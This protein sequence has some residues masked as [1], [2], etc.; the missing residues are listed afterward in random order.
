MLSKPADL[1]LMNEAILD[2]DL[3]RNTFLVFLPESLEGLIVFSGQTLQVQ[4]ELPFFNLHAVRQIVVEPLAGERIEFHL[5]KA[6]CTRLHSS[7]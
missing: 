6:I 1:L 2:E 4:N 7:K 3:L 5:K